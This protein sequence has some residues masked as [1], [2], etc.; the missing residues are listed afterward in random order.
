MNNQGIEDILTI[1]TQY[2]ILPA[3][4]KVHNKMKT[5]ITL[6]ILLITVAITTVSAQTFGMG[7]LYERGLGMNDSIKQHVYDFSLFKKPF[8][9]NPKWVYFDKSTKKPMSM[10]YYNSLVPL[11]SKVHNV[12]WYAQMTY[13]N[14]MTKGQLA[15]DFGFNFSDFSGH[16]TEILEIFMSDNVTYDISP[17]GMVIYDGVEISKKQVHTVERDAYENKTLGIVEYGWWLHVTGYESIYIKSAWCNNNTS[18]SWLA[19]HIV[20]HKEEIPA[21]VKPKAEVPKLKDEYVLLKKTT[22]IKKTTSSVVKNNVQVNNSKTSNSFAR[23]GAVNVQSNDFVT[24]SSNPV[25][26]NSTSGN[27]SIKTTFKDCGAAVNAASG[28]GVI[29]I[30]SGVSTPKANT[31][32]TTSSDE[33]DDYGAAGNVQK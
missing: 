11:L 5:K 19:T 6:L 31:A 23:A 27:G 2:A 21:P 32:T 12:S 24:T 29:V 20:R 3:N 4:K 13:I 26:V 28:S 1:L 10:N 8:K 14:A 18:T 16:L 15:K 22:I 17:E 7:L 33:D 30:D 25:A 9:M